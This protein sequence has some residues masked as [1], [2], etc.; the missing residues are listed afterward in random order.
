MASGGQ[1]REGTGQGMPCGEVWPRQA[2]GPG[3]GVLER[4]GGSRRARSLG[5]R[6]WKQKGGKEREDDEEEEEDGE[7]GKSNAGQ[8]RQCDERNR[9]PSGLGQDK[10]SNTRPAPASPA[11]SNELP[12]WTSL[13]RVGARQIGRQGETGGAGLRT[14]RA[15]LPSLSLAPKALGTAIHGRELSGGRT[16]DEVRAQANGW[17]AARSTE[18]RMR[19]QRLRRR[20]VLGFGS[21]R[22][23]PGALGQGERTWEVGKWEPE[24][25]PRRSRNETLPDASASP[26]SHAGPPLLPTSSPLDG[27]S[28]PRPRHTSCHRSARPVPAPS[29]LSLSLSL[30][31]VSPLV[32]CRGDGRSL[33]ASSCDTTAMAG[34]AAPVRDNLH[35]AGRRCLPRRPGIPSSQCRPPWLRPCAT[36]RGPASVVYAGT[37]TGCNDAH[38]PRPRPPP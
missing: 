9:G 27:T 1:R 17:P 22:G 2:E 32:V 4:A 19:H 34:C 15:G 3:N 25:P 5:R 26:P 23:A 37:S 11:P 33:P 20:P 13:R 30:P 24:R 18:C 21:D 7:G 36:C 35:A 28:H 31:P 38:P 12:T 14:R 6:E 16:G 29:S 10:R 8:G